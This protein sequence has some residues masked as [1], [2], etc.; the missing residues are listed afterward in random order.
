M[1]DQTEAITTGLG[2]A[3]ESL[4]EAQ[5]R[6]SAAAAKADEIAAQ[7]HAQYGMH[8]VARQL[9]EVSEI[10]QAGYGLVGTSAQT[11]GRAASEVG[12]VHVGMSPDTVAKELAASSGLVDDARKEM[13]AGLD[14]LD[15]AI[16]Q[17]RMAL[18]GAQP[19]P[20]VSLIEAAKQS[21]QDRALRDAN[22]A[23]DGMAAV[24]AGGG[25]LGN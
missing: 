5:Q 15:Q 19:G 12:K 1:T 7:A 23:Q 3:S 24:I 11:L 18:D 14:R 10:L 20:L 17:T 25:Q 16:T 2:T 13:F 6:I 22:S 4:G 8:A 21:V 9:N